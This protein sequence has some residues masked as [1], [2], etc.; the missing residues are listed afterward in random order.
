MIK[1]KTRRVTVLTDDEIKLV[2]GGGDPVKETDR[3]E[4]SWFCMSDGCDSNF[5]NSNDCN[6]NICN[7][8]E[9]DSNGCL[10]NDRCHTENIECEHTVPM[11]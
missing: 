10:S 8:G 3:C 7:S 2:S 1:L 6:S 5:C 11:P 4:E 9:C